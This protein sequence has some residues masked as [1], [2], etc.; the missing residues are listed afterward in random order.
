MPVASFI[1]HPPVEPTPHPYPMP[2]PDP[3]PE[4]EPNPELA[5][6]EYQG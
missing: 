3:A 4:P 6:V 5:G 2:E 1:R